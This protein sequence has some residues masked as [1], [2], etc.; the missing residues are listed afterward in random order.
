MVEQVSP[1]VLPLLP[2]P[3]PS[4]GVPIV[5]DGGSGAMLVAPTGPRSRIV[6]DKSTCPGAISAMAAS[7]LLGDGPQRGLGAGFP[8]APGTFATGLSGAP[9]VS[10]ATVSGGGLVLGVQASC[11]GWLI[12]SPAAP[13]PDL[14]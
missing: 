12:A 7:T 3:C 4:A 8:H 6:P 14:S 10:N 1:V 2:T 13:L 5:E 11:R 9:C